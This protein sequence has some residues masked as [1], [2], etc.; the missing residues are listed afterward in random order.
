MRALQASFSAACSILA[1]VH[2]VC[3]GE[4]QM[5]GARAQGHRMRAPRGC[6]GHC[7][8]T[9]PRPA[10]QRVSSC[11]P[12][13]SPAYDHRRPRRLNLAYW[14]RPHRSRPRSPPRSRHPRVPASH[15]PRT[16]LMHARPTVPPGLA[17]R[18]GASRRPRTTTT[19]YHLRSKWSVAVPCTVVYPG[20]TRVCARALRSTVFEGAWCS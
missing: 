8:G 17:E 11:P 19:T 10:R 15:K 18:A 13:P 20:H 5:G 3:K 1:C 16:R 9:W 12:P 2:A 14:T 6:G 7:G 4:G